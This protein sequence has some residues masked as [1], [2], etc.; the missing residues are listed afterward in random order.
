VA[1]A[2]RIETAVAIDLHLRP[3]RHPDLL[4]GCGVVLINPPYDPERGLERLASTTAALLAGAG[5]PDTERPVSVVKAL[6]P[7]AARRL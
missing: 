4:N 7:P 3:P 1:V 2:A 5:G 6:L